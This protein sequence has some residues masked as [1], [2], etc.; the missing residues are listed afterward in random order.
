MI[1]KKEAKCSQSEFLFVGPSNRIRP[2]NFQKGNHGI[3]FSQFFSHIINLL[4]TKL[5]GNRTGRT[6]SALG[7]NGSAQAWLIR[8]M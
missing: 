4:L 6:A 1:G 8:Y 3:Q 5:A 2:S 7:P